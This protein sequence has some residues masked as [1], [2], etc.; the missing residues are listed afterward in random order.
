MFPIKNGRKTKQSLP[1]QATHDLLRELVRAGDPGGWVVTAAFAASLANRRGR[2]LKPR[3]PWGEGL[4]G[5]IVPKPKLLGRPP[6]LTHEQRRRGVERIEQIQA[7][8]VSRMGRPVPY[9]EAIRYCVEFFLHPKGH[10]SYTAKKM[11][12]R[13][14]AAISNT[15]YRARK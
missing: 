14:V 4:L 13:S 5:R 10:D 12:E 2:P 3:S 15:F 1:T 8:M 11:V 7:A 6:T 9:S